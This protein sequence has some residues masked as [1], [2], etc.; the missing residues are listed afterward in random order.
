MDSIAGCRGEDPR[1]SGNYLKF[2]ALV[3]K[4]DSVADTGNLL[5][6][7]QKLCS[8]LLRKRGNVSFRT[9]RHR[10][11]PSYKAGFLHYF[12]CL[13]DNMILE[14]A[15]CGI[16]YKGCKCRLFSDKTDLVWTRIPKKPFIHG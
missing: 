7:K 11:R 3:Y 1:T 8:G 6:R 12:V 16:V 5:R 2:W 15:E 9:E 4:V 14:G 13:S 10:N